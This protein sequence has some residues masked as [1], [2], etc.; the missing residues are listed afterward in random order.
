M[1]FLWLFLPILFGGQVG[2]GEAW[3][4]GA[5]VG[6]VGFYMI[7]FAVSSRDEYALL[8]QAT[9]ADPNNVTT[10]LDEGLV[11]TADT[12]APVVGDGH[13]EPVSPLTG[14]PAIHAEWIVQQ[15]QNLGIRA[16]W[17]N[18]ATGVHTAP[19]TL[20][21]ATIEVTPG[22]H[23]TLST[24]ES[25]FTIQPGD[26]IPDE[27][28]AFLASHPDL[29]D[30]AEMNSPIRIIETVVPTDEPV[31]VV[32]TPRQAAE[33]TIR[34]DN[35]PVDEL[36][37]TPTDHAATANDNSGDGRQ[38]EGGEVILLNG[39]VAAARR[40]L[41][42]RVYWLGAFGLAFILAGQALA[43]WLAGVSVL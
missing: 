12:P 4:F 33:P 43:L 26:D 11:A 22:T 15:R 19:F 34:I 20:G 38:G 10:G 32:G 24:H 21:D 31:T 8:K 42:K 23:R 30:P 7:A 6:G 14:T 1:S 5:A 13:P 29:S 40:F 25:N 3:L 28:A 41:K 18:V 35:A 2:D 16:V 9:S 36:L 27:T 37:A 39:E 17:R